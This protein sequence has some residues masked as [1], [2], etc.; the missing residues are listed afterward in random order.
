M[1]RR[2]GFTL[3]EVLIVVG[4]SGGLMVA[5]LAN[6]DA[7]RR[8]VDAIHNVM[9]TESNG[10]RILDQIRS[11]L[12]HLAVYDAAEYRIFK[13]EN[14][15]ILGADADR[16]DML[17][18]GR[19]RL[20]VNVPGVGDGLHA[21]LTEVG[22]RLRTNPLRTDFLELY[23]REDALVDDE[24]WRDGGYAL[25]YDRVVSFNLR[26]A[27]KPDHNL[28]W[29]EGWDSEQREALPFGIEIFLEIEVQPR[30][31]RESLGIIGANRAR[32]SFN[33][34]MLVPSHQRWIFRNRL[35]P[36]LPEVGTAG[37][38]DPAAAGGTPDP[39]SL[40]G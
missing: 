31:S 35:H 2:S 3:V 37:A 7:T 17:V 38:G 24:P 27:A 21:P 11:D 22:Y 29:D 40:G 32:L 12:G 18:S 15:S 10:P 1:K 5:V 14:A 30:N 6:L 26:Y 20:G 36:T 8:A 16:M 19:S 39:S 23:R 9:E 25:L 33:D 13:G 34:L 4:M 28:S